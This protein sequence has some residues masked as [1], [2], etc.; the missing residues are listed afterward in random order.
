[1][2]I[3]FC[4]CM[5]CFLSSWGIQYLFLNNLRENTAYISCFP[6][7]SVEYQLVKEVVPPF[8]GIFTTFAISVVPIA[9]VIYLVYIFMIC[10]KKKDSDFIQALKISWG[11]RNKF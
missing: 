4:F 11:N 10:T 8:D 2:Y 3:Y 7:N 1:M 6:E 9:N 5:F